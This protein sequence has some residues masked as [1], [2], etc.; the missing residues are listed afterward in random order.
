[1]RSSVI[2][3]VA[4]LVI[5]CGGEPVEPCVEEFIE[6]TDSDT[7]PEVADFAERGWDCELISTRRDPIFGIATLR[8][9]LCSRCR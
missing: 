6:F 8:T 7:R 1:M 5:R 9:W 3:A 4:V 2:L